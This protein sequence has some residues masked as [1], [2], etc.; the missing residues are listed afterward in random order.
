MAKSRS[1]LSLFGAPEKRHRVYVRYTEQA[2][3][4][5]VRSDYMR[6]AEEARLSLRDALGIILAQVLPAEMAI[7]GET[8]SGGF[9]TGLGIDL[10]VYQSPPHYPAETLGALIQAIA[11]AKTVG[12]LR[13]DGQIGSI[14]ESYKRLYIEIQGANLRIRLYMRC[15]WLLDPDRCIP[16][17]TARDNAIYVEGG[18]TYLMAFYSDI[19][20]G[21]WRTHRPSVTPTILSAHKKSDLLL[22]HCRRLAKTCK[23]R[24]DAAVVV[25][26]DPDPDYYV[27]V[28]GL[29]Q[30]FRY[31][32][33]VRGNQLQYIRLGECLV[34]KQL[35]ETI[36]WFWC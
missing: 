36:A 33:K 26:G 13:L 11:Q 18:P 3:L 12:Y 21:V 19:I 24:A 16:L 15:N 30:G 35:G 2:G 7:I 32:R 9:A 8:D 6:S 14:G 20:G 34:T 25:Y 10:P 4:L 17:D 22:K 31:P 28:E 27:Y 5:E 23:P 29:T 1:R